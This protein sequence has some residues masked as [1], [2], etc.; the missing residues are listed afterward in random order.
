MNGELAQSI[1]EPI[2]I[3]IDVEW[4]LIPVDGIIFPGWWKELP[5]TENIDVERR[6]SAWSDNSG[7]SRSPQSAIGA[8][9]PVMRA[10][11]AAAYVDEVSVQS[12]RRKVGSVYP[13][14]INVSGRGQAWL[15][16]HLD[17]A[18]AKLKG[19]VAGIVDAA[20][21]L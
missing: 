20:D 4:E 17:Q 15:K 18:I 11:T 5:A 16:D 1:I 6:T 13:L 2:C 3:P 12:F 21:L 7:P 14:P 10:E 9:P 19:D 8:W